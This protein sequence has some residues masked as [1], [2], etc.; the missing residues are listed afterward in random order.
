M[1]VSH[2]SIC[3]DGTDVDVFF[4]DSDFHSLNLWIAYHWK[5][6]VGKHSV[7]FSYTPSVDVSAEHGINS[8]IIQ[9]RNQSFT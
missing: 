1:T 8:C 3:V 7:W 5:F 2:D 9:M 6:C 4:C